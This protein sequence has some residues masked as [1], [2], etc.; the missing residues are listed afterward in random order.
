MLALK[1][2]I[3][4][5]LAEIIF[6]VSINSRYLSKCYISLIFILVPAIDNISPEHIEV[7]V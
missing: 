3:A 5:T 1:V 2:L 4:A 7:D 6:V